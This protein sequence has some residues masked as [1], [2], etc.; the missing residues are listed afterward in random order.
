MTEKMNKDLAKR[1]FVLIV[2][3]SNLMRGKCDLFENWYTDKN[4]LDESY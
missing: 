2:L 4:I 3:A 1:K